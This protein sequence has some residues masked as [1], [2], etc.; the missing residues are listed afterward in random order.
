MRPVSAPVLLRVMELTYGGIRPPVGLSYA[1]SARY[2]QNS[3]VDYVT[4]AEVKDRTHL[5]DKE[6]RIRRR[7]PFGHMARMQSGVPAHDTQ[8]TAL[9]VRIAVV[10]FHIQTGSNPAGGQPQTI[11]A[12][13]Q[14][15]PRWN[16]PLCKV[17]WLWIRMDGRSSLRAF[18]ALTLE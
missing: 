15:G 16:G 18:A 3:L 7:R 8:W 6:P 13:A 9:G 4:N 10:P 12:E 1:E 5:K 17:W 14:E 11:W 2:T